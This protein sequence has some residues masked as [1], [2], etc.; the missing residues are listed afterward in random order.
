MPRVHAQTVQL[1]GVGGAQ[2]GR[3]PKRKAHQA[4]SMGLH[5]TMEFGG[6]H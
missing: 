3:S 5:V 1:E 2:G 6:V 4:W